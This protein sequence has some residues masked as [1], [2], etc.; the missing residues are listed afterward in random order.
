MPGRVLHVR[1]SAFEDTVRGHAG[2]N[3][4]FGASLGN[5]GYAA[6]G[7]TDTLSDAGLAGRGVTVRVTGDDSRDAA[8]GTTDG[9]DHP[10]RI[11]ALQPTWKTGRVGVGTGMPCPPNPA[12]RR[13]SPARSPRT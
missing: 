7:G 1:G 9:I 3:E 11:A 5:D 8:K 12:C 4:I 6:Q 10:S 13:L 2:G